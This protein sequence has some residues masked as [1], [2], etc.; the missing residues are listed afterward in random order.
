[1]TAGS[2]QYEGTVVPDAEGTLYAKVVLTGEYFTDSSDPIEIIVKGTSLF[3][4]PSSQTQTDG[5]SDFPFIPILIAVV[6]VIVIIV[7]L[8]L[9][10]KIKKAKPDLFG[11]MKIVIKRNYEASPADWRRLAPYGKEANLLDLL[12]RAPEFNEVREIRILGDDNAIR[13]LSSGQPEIYFSD[14]QNGFDVRLRDS[15]GFEI[16]LQD[17]VTII[18]CT[19]SRS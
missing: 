13:V 11:T 7:A 17:N 3:G 16:R 6:L 14:G 4:K 5:S 9:L 1:M 19:W 2:L 18:E 8:I 12:D 15:E 10:R